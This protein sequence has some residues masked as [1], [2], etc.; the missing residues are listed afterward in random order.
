V[1]DP[2]FVPDPGSPTETTLPMARYIFSGELLLHLQVPV[3]IKLVR[4]DQLL[5]SGGSSSGLL[6]VRVEGDREIP[7]TTDREV[8]LWVSLG[9]P[10][11]HEFHVVSPSA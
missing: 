9:C 4:G 1:S 7:D 10:V 6:V 5:D 11:N 3:G 2:E 8:L